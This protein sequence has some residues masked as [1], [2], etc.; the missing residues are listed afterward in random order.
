[1]TIRFDDQVAIV[2][3]AG[4]G[5][6][7]S[8]ALEFA[9]RGARV[10]VNDLGGS[11]KGTGQSHSAADQVVKEIRAAGGQAIANYDSVENGEA[12]VQ[13]AMDHFG[14]VDIVINNAGILR[15]KSFTKMSDEDWDLV[16]RVHLLGAY[17]VAH[18]AWPIM[19]QQAYG[20]IINTSSAAGIY[21]NFGQA[22]YS[23]AKLGLYGLTQT[24]A[25]EGAKYNIRVN[26]IAPIAGSRLMASITP[27]QLLAALKSEYV[28]PLVVRLCMQASQETGSLFEV[29]GGWM[30]KLRWE[31]TQGLAFAPD[32]PFSTE[33]IDAQ[34]QQL[35][36]FHQATHPS[37][38]NQEP[39][40]KPVF[41]NLGLD[42]TV[43]S[44][45]PQASPNK[46]G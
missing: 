35:C 1:M 22:N 18:A 29:G 16:Y 30:A 25:Q 10:V 32:Q 8:H 34:W 12:I 39:P 45:G 42:F 44:L 5:L 46:E 33:E 13:T 38:F 7:R 19:R 23:S 2:T 20:R 17:K 11:T 28:T 4:A 27:E 15:D 21:G 41:D 31:R 24:L 14:R 26:A 3:G 36:D 9:R 40:L 6:G 37:H 43:A